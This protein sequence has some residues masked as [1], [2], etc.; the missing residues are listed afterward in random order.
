MPWPTHHRP[1]TAIA[2]L[3]AAL[4][5]GQVHALQEGMWGAGYRFASGGVS[6]GAQDDYRSA[7]EAIGSIDL[8]RVSVQP[9]KPLA[10]G[11][12]QAGDGRTVLL[13][14][15]PGNPV[16]P[17]RNTLMASLKKTPCAT[18]WDSTVLP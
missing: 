13:F 17:I 18:C 12:A 9:G 5:A 16:T 7:F 11:R 1:G 2:L 14:G 6:V 3:A 8:W 4:G 10:F 15:L